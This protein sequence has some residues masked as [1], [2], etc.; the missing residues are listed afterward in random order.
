VTRNDLSLN[1][2]ASFIATLMRYP[3]K[4]GWTFAVV[5]DEH[6]PPV[7]G[8]WGRTPVLASVDG[9]SW[10]TSVWRGKDGITMLPVPKQIRG[11]KEDGD[12]VSVEVIFPRPMP[13]HDA[14]NKHERTPVRALGEVALRVNDLDRSQ[15]FYAN[16][17]GLE[18]MRRFEHAVFF[19]ISD[20]YAGHTTVLALFKRE[21]SVEQARSTVDHLAFTI[22]LEDYEPEKARLEATGLHVTTTTH[23]WVSWRSIYV[24]DPDGNTVELVCFDP[25]V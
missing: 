25:T 14:L 6:A 18:L 1:P 9:R 4:G 3:G 10:E 17:I 22:A 13:A 16:V 19:R 7:T 15:A 12:A 21:T 23:G 11:S 20:G 5:P 24:E 2:A 8:G